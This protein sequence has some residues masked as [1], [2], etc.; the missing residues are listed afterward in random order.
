MFQRSRLASADLTGEDSLDGQAGNFWVV[1]H[2]SPTS[3]AIINLPN[4]FT[5]L[6]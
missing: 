6:W 3:T 2:P 5:V 4:R 1:L